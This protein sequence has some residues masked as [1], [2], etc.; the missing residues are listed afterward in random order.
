MDHLARGKLQTLPGPLQGHLLPFRGQSANWTSVASSRGTPPDKGTLAN[1][2]GTAQDRI[3]G[4]PLAIASSPVEESDRSCASGRSSFRE[5]GFS[6][7]VVKTSQGCP[8]QEA[9]KTTVC[10][11][12]ENR[13]LLTNPRRKVSRSNLGWE[14]GGDFQSSLPASR[15]AA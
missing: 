6:T 4:R 8:S 1:V 15:A 11:S 3:V 12:E 5:I 10:P 14:G 7:R 13:A 9:L 2:P